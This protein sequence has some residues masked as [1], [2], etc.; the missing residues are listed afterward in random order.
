MDSATFLEA[1][2]NLPLKPVYVVHGEEDFLKRQVLA[3]LRQ[4]CFGTEEESLGWTVL[5][6]E[7]AEFAAVRDELSTLGFLADHRLVQISQADTF[8]TD[9]RAQLEK[10]VAEPSS[11][12]TL[13]LEVKSWPANTKLSKL[14]PADATL[15]CKTLPAGRLPDWCVRWARSNYGKQISSAAAR[16][17]VELAGSETGILDQELAKLSVYV[18][19]AAKI[20]EPDVDRL[21]G[22]NRAQTVWKIFE[23]IGAG[24]MAEAL[25]L[26]DKLLE[27]GEEPLRILGAFGSQLRKLP[28]AATLAGTGMSMHAALQQAGVA[29]FNIRVAEQQLR[30]LGRKRVERIYDWLLEVDSGLKGGSELQPRLQLER[31][32]VQLTRPDRETKAAPSR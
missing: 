17:L 13:V 8:V 23:F 3:K 30:H 10:Y 29:P 27:Q 5:E 26:L 28:Q 14:V 9:Y 16:L 12:G 7:R 4:L 1:G 25:G 11:R 18:G 32:V 2:K 24:Q 20:E 31:L 15:V 22:N 19:S 21:V 6:G